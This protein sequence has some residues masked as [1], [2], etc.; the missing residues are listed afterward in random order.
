MTITRLRPWTEQS[1]GFYS[2]GFVETADNIIPVRVRTPDPD[3]FGDSIPKIINCQGITLGPE[4][5]RKAATVEAN[6]G[7]AAITFGYTN[8]KNCIEPLQCNA[9][10]V[11]SIME[12][13]DADEYDILGFSMGGAVAAI[14]AML[15]K[16]RIRNLHLASPGALTD[17]VSEVDNKRLVEA[18]QGEAKDKYQATRRDPRTAAYTALSSMGNCINRPKAVRAEAA[19][20]LSQTVYPYLEQFRQQSPETVITLAHGSDD[21]LVPSKELVA[22]M[23]DHEEALGFPIVDRYVGYKGTHVSII[24]DSS[25]T[26]RILEMS[27]SD[28][29]VNQMA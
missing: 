29:T 23:H 3:V 18:V 7:F 5:M 11:I 19:Q 2:S 12:A 17:G 15:A 6:L 26:E 10:D 22:S 27:A 24:Y 14:T 21:K 1:Y 13:F 28:S 8:K 9:L 20:L 16:R 25:L 4:A